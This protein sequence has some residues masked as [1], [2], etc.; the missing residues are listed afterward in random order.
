MPVQSLGIDI[1]GT[2]IKA[3]IVGPRGLEGEIRQVP[4]PSHPDAIIDT[5]LALA[6]SFPVQPTVGV[7]VA[8]FLDPARTH[9]EFSPNIAWDGRPLRHELEEGLQLPVVLE[10][11]ANAAGY[12][13]YVLGA[14]QQASPMVMLT[15]GTG[16][17]GAVILDGKLLAGARGVAG[18]LGHIVVNPGGAVCGCGQRGCV[19]TVSSGTALMTM[20]RQALGIEINSTHALKQALVDAPELRKTLLNTMA[21]GIIG[22]LLQIQAVVDPALSVIGG[23]VTERLG[24]ELFDALDRLKDDALDRRRSVAFPPIVP[25]ELGNSAGII[26]AGLLAQR[27][28]VHSAH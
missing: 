3:G 22:A 14:G 25:A 19:E 24:A 17:G 23:G 26:G 10:N 2:S 21:E 27:H 16:V 6:K 7:A 28:D 18:E 8:A 4:T 20:A 9:V 5:T 15:L 12:G 13:E 1:G 11:D